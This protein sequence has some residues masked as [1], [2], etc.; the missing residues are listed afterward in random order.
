MTHTERPL[1]SWESV[2]YNAWKVVN[3]HTDLEYVVTTRQL[4]Y[5]MF[6]AC[7][8]AGIAL[9]REAHDKRRKPAPEGSPARPD[10]AIDV[11]ARNLSLTRRRVKQILEGY[12]H[13]LEQE[14]THGE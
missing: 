14:T 11:V 5:A 1:V 7:R 8:I 4:A 12:Y 3:R 9:E 2:G 10:D 13:I 6:D